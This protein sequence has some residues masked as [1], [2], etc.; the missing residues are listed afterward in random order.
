MFV[1]RSFIR[2]FVGSPI[3][4][5]VGW[6]V[7]LVGLVVCLLACLLVYSLA[8]TSYVFKYSGTFNKMLLARVNFEQF[9]GSSI[10]VQLV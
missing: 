10:I 1:V 4:W 2:S 8:L 3:R 6:L 9:C 7:D 5:L